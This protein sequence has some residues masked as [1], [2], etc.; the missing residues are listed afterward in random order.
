MCRSIVDGAPNKVNTIISFRENKKLI[1]NFNFLY[2]YRNR[3][4]R[5][6]FVSTAFFVAR[7]VSVA[8]TD[9]SFSNSVTTVA[10]TRPIYEA[11]SNNQSKK[12]S[13]NQ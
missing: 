1:K 8:A 2:E 7:E 9:F 13:I 11:G 10:V 3:T 6:G 5:D 4:F 12:K